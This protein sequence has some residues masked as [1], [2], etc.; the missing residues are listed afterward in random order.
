[1]RWSRPGVARRYADD[2]DL[3][4]LK[5][6]D[7]SLELA[8]RWCFLGKD[9]PTDMRI[10]IF[11]A[12]ALSQSEELEQLRSRVAELEKLTNEIGLRREKSA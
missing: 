6:I 8:G 3:Q 1:M 7:Y 10:E 2:E 5:Q 12:N 4:T 9:I 11:V